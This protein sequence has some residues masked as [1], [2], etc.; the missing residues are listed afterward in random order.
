VAA[1]T[2]GPPQLPDGDLIQRRFRLYDAA[3]EYVSPEGRPADIAVVDGARVI[4][5]HPPRGNY[6]WA[7]GRI[8]EHMVPTLTLGETMTGGEAQAWRARITPADE[9]EIF[10]RS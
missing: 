3:G 8:Y 2:T 10:A 7:G 1:A 9:T 4:V 6:Q 5:L